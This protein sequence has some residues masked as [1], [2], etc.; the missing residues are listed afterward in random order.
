MVG[1]MLT[2]KSKSK[3]N[4]FEKYDEFA[5]GSNIVAGSVNL[6]VANDATIIGSKIKA[7]NGNLD[8]RATNIYT[9]GA[10]ET[11]S[12]STSNS[13]SVINMLQSSMKKNNCK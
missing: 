9:A 4:T 5:K 8:I 6:N 11:H 2:S 7:T 13:N 12:I 3:E 10:N 1:S